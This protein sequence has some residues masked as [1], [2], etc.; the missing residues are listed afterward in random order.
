MKFDFDFLKS[1][2]DD[3]L[4]RKEQITTALTLPVS[5]LFVLGTLMIAMEQSFSYM[6]DFLT[7]LFLIFLGLTAF[8]FLICVVYVGRT[9]YSRP[10]M[11]LPHLGDLHK[12]RVAWQGTLQAG[13]SGRV[14]Q[15]DRIVRPFIAAARG[16]C[17]RSIP[18][19]AGNEND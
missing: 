3:E 14:L 10:Y 16:I 12:T 8:A 13:I 11:Y 5:V 7:C 18:A 2:Y 17:G 4:E 6:D 19:L 9:Y 15:T 1:R